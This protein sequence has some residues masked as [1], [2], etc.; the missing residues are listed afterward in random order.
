MR[1]MLP[2]DIPALADIA[3]EAFWNDEVFAWIFPDRAQFPD[4]FKRNWVGIFRFHL[5]KPGWHCFVSETEEG[6]PMWSGRSDLTGFAM[7]ERR[8]YSS[9]AKSW[10]QDSISNC[11]SLF[12]IKDLRADEDDDSRAEAPSWHELCLQ[13]LLFANSLS[14]SAQSSAFQG[15]HQRW[16]CRGERG[17]VP[18]DDWSVA[19][20][21]TPRNW[22]LAD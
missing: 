17:M 2:A 10:Q 5:Y 1:R 4:D 3:T 14:Q 22:N 19:E 18:F 12:S 8:G 9:V 11:M 21:P 7:W 20:T 16:S 15:G 6:D 13:L